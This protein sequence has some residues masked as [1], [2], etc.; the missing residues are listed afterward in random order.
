MYDSY[1]CGHGEHKNSKTE[2]IIACNTS[3]YVCIINCLIFLN[4]NHVLIDNTIRP[5][6]QNP[7]L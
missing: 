2:F 4:D 7:V 5:L 3:V 6:P 1:S